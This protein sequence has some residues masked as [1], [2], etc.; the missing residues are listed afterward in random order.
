[1]RDDGQKPH[2]RLSLRASQPHMAKPTSSGDRV[3]A[4]FVYGLRPVGKVHVLIRGDLR[5]T[6]QEVHERNPEWVYPVDQ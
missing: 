3:N 5:V 2:I 1:M 4:A 6:R